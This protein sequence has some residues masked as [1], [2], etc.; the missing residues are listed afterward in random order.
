MHGWQSL[1]VLRLAIAL[2]WMTDHT[3]PIAPSSDF[4]F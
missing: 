3:A 4:L 1:M 2:V